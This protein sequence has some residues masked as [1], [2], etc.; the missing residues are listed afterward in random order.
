MK[1][2]NIIIILT[3][4]FAS[5]SKDKKG[6][7]F[8]YTKNYPGDTWENH[9][10]GLLWTLSYLGA[11]LPPG[12]FDKAIQWKDSTTFTFDFSK[13]GFSE[14]ALKSVNVICDSIMSAD[15][16][17]ANNAADI[18]LFTA[19]TIGTS[20]HYYKITNVPVSMKELV[21]QHKVGV[22]RLFPVTK[23][24]VAKHHRLLKYPKDT[25]NVVKWLFIAEEGH[26]SFNDK[27]FSAET[28]EVFDVMPNGQLRF[29]IYDKNGQLIKGSPKEFGDA[30]KPAKCL[31]CHE[32]VIQPL[33]DKNAAVDS[34]IQPHEFQSHILSF[35][36]R[37]IEYRRGLKSDLDFNKTQDHTQMELEYIS[38]MQPSIKKLEKEWNM[39]EDEVKQLLKSVK[40]VTHE[41][42]KF[43]GEIY[44]RTEIHKGRSLYPP[45]I[46][47]PGEHEPDFFK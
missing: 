19:L 32:I 42:F 5:C 2:F 1:Y 12:S 11:T 44:N 25:M 26:G 10:T 23:S 27:T 36:K 21:D 4:L 29:M 46:R 7:Q 15:S 33:F 20:A 13:I 43:L 30:G 24:T 3:F 41:E 17:N 37:L 6:I 22:T 35:M 45:S 14:N 39:R 47:E 40:S 8:Y 18:G 28:F 9:R 16:Y 38:Y 34:F 31:W